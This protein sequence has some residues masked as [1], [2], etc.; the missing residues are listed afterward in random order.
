MQ[1]IETIQLVLWYFAPAGQVIVAIVMIRHRLI[2]EVPWFFAYTIFH[3]IQF[4]VMIATYHY[5][6]SAYFYSY[7]T[8]EGLDVLL[9]LVVIQEIYD[10]AFRPFEALR[11]L[12][13]GLFRWAVIVLLGISLL[14]AA[15]AS[16]TEHDR[17]IASLLIVDR[18]ACFVQCALIFLLFMM[19]Q[20]I[21][22]PWRRVSHG[23]AIGLGMI[24]ASTSIAMTVRAYSHRQLD[25]IISVVLACTYD[26]AIVAWIAMLLRPE[27]IPNRA[28]LVPAA[29]LQKWDSALM[30]LMNK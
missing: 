14:V 3:L 22:V 1:L 7:W 4:V 28:N 30:E 5:S 24:A 8:M 20:A 26:L 27:P 23:I 18:S 13:T 19:K 2:R 25:G 9:V 21:G 15:S 10:Q 29:T 6:Y 11:G 17:F 16:G 12:S